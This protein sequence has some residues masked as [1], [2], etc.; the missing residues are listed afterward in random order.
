MY[1]SKELDTY[2]FDSVDDI[3]KALIDDVST[4]NNYVFNKIKNHIETDIDTIETLT[5]FYV[6][7]EGTLYN[8]KISR[9]KLISP[10]KKCLDKFIEVEDYEKCIE[11]RDLIEKMEK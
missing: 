2:I 10:L 4:I 9:T 6:Q 1:Y 11:C 8:V 7:L 3:N 5:L